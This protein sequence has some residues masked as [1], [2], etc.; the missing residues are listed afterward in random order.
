[1]LLK[2]PLPNLHVGRPHKTPAKTLRRAAAAAKSL[3]VQT[4]GVQVLRAQVPPVHGP[5]PRERFPRA[6]RQR[7]LLTRL[8]AA[9]RGLR[10]G[11][12]RDPARSSSSPAQSWGYFD[13]CVDDNDY[14]VYSA[15][16]LPF[17]G[18]ANGVVVE[19]IRTNVGVFPD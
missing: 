17:V 12:P 5:K 10:G 2:A 11:H 3:E 18:T 14:A 6:R 7:L 15:L 13:V 4:A 1:M 9:A 19:A 16:Q 8:T